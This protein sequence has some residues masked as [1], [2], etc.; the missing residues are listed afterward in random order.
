[1]LWVGTSPLARPVRTAKP[2]KLYQRSRARF[3]MPVLRVLLTSW[4]VGS[5]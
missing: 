1:M 4:I 5:S 2:S 3:L